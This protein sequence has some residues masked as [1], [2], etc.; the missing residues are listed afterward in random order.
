MGQIEIEIMDTA[1]SK[2]KRARLPDD[3]PVNRMMP[4][5]ITKMNLPVTDPA[6]QPVSYHLDHKQSGKRLR[7]EDTLN[8]AGVKSG[9][10]L[11]IAAEITAG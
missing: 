4:V 10:L 7:D 3:A 8:N 11:R 1:G 9:D 6:G 5:L 2:R